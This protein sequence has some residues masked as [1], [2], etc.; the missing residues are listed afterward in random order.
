MKDPNRVKMKKETAKDKVINICELLAE[1]Y[2]KLT[3]DTIQEAA[4]DLHDIEYACRKIAQQI[5]R[6]RCGV[7]PAE[8]ISKTLD[9]VEYE[10]V[11]HIGRMHLPTLCK[12]IKACNQ[13]ERS[14]VSNKPKTAHV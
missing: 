14:K 2:P 7:V 8:D 13:Q 4:V 5:K 3:D 10:L 1:R 9:S 12:F 11:D 6:L